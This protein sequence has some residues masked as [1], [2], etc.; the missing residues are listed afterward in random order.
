MS[1]LA[2]HLYLLVSTRSRDPRAAEILGYTHALAA[3]AAGVALALGARLAIAWCVVAA[4]GTFLALRLAICHRWTIFAAAVIG[5]TLVASIGGALGWL[6]AMTSDG[7]VA[8]VPAIL[9]GA[10]A[11]AAVPLHAYVR[12]IGRRLRGDR[13]SL[14]PPDSLDDAHNDLR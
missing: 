12:M 6:L 1:G 5:T 8:S 7:G 2:R 4:I 9:V 10:C 13:D 3:L 14:L 11:A